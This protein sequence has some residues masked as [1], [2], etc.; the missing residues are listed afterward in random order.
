[1]LS[2]TLLI[3][4]AII[5]FL[6]G[7]AGIVLPALP[8]LPVIWLGILTYGFATG[9]SKITVGVV[10]ITG[11][12]ALVGVLVD[13]LAGMF[14][15]KTFGASWYG[16]LGAL[17]GGLFG[18][19]TG[20]VFGLFAGSF[21]GAWL[22]EYLKYERTVKATKAGFGTIAGIVFGMVLKIIFAL[23]MIGIFVWKVV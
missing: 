11:V 17:L 4:I 3:V 2:T 12:L 6:I 21:I 13:F 23:L 10:V 9:F 20:S 7:L 22:G 18:F 5:L 1:M 8:G 14:G 19:V 16:V 15:A